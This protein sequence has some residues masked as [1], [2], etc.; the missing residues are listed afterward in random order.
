MTNL[1]DFNEWY[2]FRLRMSTI[3]RTRILFNVQQMGRLIR[4]K[5]INDSPTSDSILRMLFSP[6]TENTI[7]AEEILKSYGR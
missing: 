4:H 2:D 6:D 3:N 7:L 5:K 1:E